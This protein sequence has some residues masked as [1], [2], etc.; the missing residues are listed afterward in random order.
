VLLPLFLFSENS[1][2][3]NAITS[4]LEKLTLIHAEKQYS[5]VWVVFFF[6]VMYSMLGH[7]FIYFFEE[8]RKSLAVEY[9]SDPTGLTEV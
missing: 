1:E 6:T 2:N 5:M 4:S 8:K 7:I 3:N 9:S